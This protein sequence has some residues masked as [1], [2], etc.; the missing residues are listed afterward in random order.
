MHLSR[1]YCAV[2]MDE[3][4]Q[5]CREYPTPLLRTQ[6]EGRPMGGQGQVV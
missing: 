3:I 1:G 6:G 4:E 5:V 2:P